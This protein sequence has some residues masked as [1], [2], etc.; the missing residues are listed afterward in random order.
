MVTLIGRLKQWGGR[1]RPSPSVT[2]CD[3]C[4]GLRLCHCYPR[5]VWSG[6]RPSRC[7]L[8]APCSRVLCRPS[9][10]VVNGIGA[11]FRGLART[12]F[13]KKF[14][15]VSQRLQQRRDWGLGPLKGSPMEE[16][17]GRS[18]RGVSSKLAS[19]LGPCGSGGKS[20]SL[21]LSATCPTS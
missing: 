17:S 8:L 21:V 3:S 2:S 9:A 14:L 4:G 19:Q 12:L 13:R 1:H 15:H 18:F 10:F 7:S 6:V 5:V 11:V 20:R 16:H